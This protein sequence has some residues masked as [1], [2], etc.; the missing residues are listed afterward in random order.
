MTKTMLV[1]F[2]ILLASAS[3]YAQ[4]GALNDTGQT[5]CFDDSGAVVCN[6]VAADAGT[7]PRQDG[8]FGRDVATLTKI[9]GGAAG[10]DFSRICWNGSIEGATNCAG[11]LLGN[12]GNAPS[13]SA[14]TDWACTKDNVTNL[15]WS[16]ETISG[17]DW[18][19]TDWVSAGSAATSSSHNNVGRCGYNSGWRLPTVHELLS[20]VH[21]GST[22][23]VKID[24]D[25]FPFALA[26]A[27]WSSNT[28]A[29]NPDAKA[30]LVNFAF[31]DPNTGFKTARVLIRL[32]RSAQ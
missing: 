16:L 4:I 1:G 10:F 31:G 22:R 3:V 15:V 14:S 2:G 29:L 23:G 26:D 13:A 6:T 19:G 18:V 32:V 28:Y 30:W 7:F 12:I 21:H 25:Y 5:Q 24:I 11:S 17:A 27:Y 20:L 8:R 9:G